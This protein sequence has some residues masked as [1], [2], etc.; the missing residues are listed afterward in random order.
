MRFERLEGI[1]LSFFHFFHFCV[2]EDFD[3]RLERFTHE[4]A[5]RLCDEA[6]LFL[7]KLEA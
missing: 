7:L 1:N 2:A 4:Q 6:F 5:K 3:R